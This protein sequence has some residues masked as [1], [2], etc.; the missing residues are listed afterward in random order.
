MIF[1]YHH[2]DEGLLSNMK[3]KLSLPNSLETFPMIDQTFLSWKLF[4]EKLIKSFIYLQ[5][6]ISQINMASN[7]HHLIC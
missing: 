5:T 2:I 6:V 1:F 4:Y 7:S 3:E